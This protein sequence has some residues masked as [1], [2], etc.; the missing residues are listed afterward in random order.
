MKDYGFEFVV[1][2]GVYPPSEDTYLLIDAIE[3]DQ[4]DVFLE[5]GCGAGLV[6]MTAAVESRKVIATDISLE[7][8]RNTRKNMISNR[9][10]EKCTL[11]QTDLLNPLL[12]STEPSVIAFNPPYLPDDDERTSVDSMTVGGPLGQELSEGFIRQASRLLKS[13]G[14]VYFVASSRANLDN[15]KE[16]MKNTHFNFECARRKRL[17]FEELMVFKGTRVPKETIL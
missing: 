2:S 16:T 13:G 10:Q 6:S 7:A 5:V 8:L 3:L 11:I 9:L 14:T 17:F 15:L 4:D 12:G 1:N